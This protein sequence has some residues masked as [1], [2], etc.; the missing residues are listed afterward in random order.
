M[1]DEQIMLQIE[2]DNALFMIVM[3]IVFIVIGIMY[4]IFFIELVKM[5]VI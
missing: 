4:A 2:K 3:G 5:G 1:D